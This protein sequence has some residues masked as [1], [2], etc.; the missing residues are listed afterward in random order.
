[1]IHTFPT[2]IQKYEPTTTMVNQNVQNTMIPSIPLIKD[3]LE[4]LP[5]EI[6]ISTINE[7]TEEINNMT[8]QNNN[9]LIGT[10]IISLCSNIEKEQL[11]SKLTKEIFDSYSYDKTP[12]IYNSKDDF[13][14]SISDTQNEKSNLNSPNDFPII[15]LGECEIILKRKN[16]IPLNSEL[17]ILKIEKINPDFIDY[18]IYNPITYEKLNLSICNNI[19]LYIPYNLS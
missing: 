12:K 3:Y 6:I 8:I 11:Y 2:T 7:I 4:E 9:C 1:M 16:N 18:E 17:I 10:D 19:D 14:L 15:D 13:K 5:K